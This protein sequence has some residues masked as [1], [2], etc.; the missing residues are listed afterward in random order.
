MSK[1]IIKP[2]V[3]KI[4]RDTEKPQLNSTYLEYV[5]TTKKGIKYFRH[6]GGFNSYVKDS[7]FVCFFHTPYLFEL[8]ENESYEFLG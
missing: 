8:D 5:R 7:E 4:Y 3:G 2:V 1:L 6:V